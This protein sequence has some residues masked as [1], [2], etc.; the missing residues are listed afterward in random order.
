MISMEDIESLAELLKERNMIDSKIV[1]I[2]HRPAEKGHMAEWIASQAFPIELNDKANR[3]DDDGV[4]TDGE[5]KGK[6]VDVKFHSLNE[7]LINLNK[8]AAEDVWLL[9]FTGPYE[10]AGH[11]RKKN[12]PFR[13][14]NTYLFNEKELC[15]D[16]KKQKRKV[17][18]G[19]SLKREYW[20]KAEIYPEDKAGYDLV[21]KR[22][23][24]ERFDLKHEEV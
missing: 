12:R 19:T 20:E 24:L 23:V 11:P 17:G 18:V 4:F 5:L 15:N 21:I 6:K 8:E 7:H 9:V 22:E 16:L 14:T 1:G 3:R 13:I 10:P 2:I